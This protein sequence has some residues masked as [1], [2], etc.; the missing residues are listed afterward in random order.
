MNNEEIAVFRYEFFS[1]LRT[2][3]LLNHGYFTKILFVDIIL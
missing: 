3:M 1:F 2:D